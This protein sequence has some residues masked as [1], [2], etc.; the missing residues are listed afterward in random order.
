[1]ELCRCRIYGFPR[2]NMALKDVVT[3]YL[4]S[5]RCILFFIFIF[6]FSLGKLW[7]KNKGGFVLEEKADKLR[8]LQY[9]A[10]T[11]S[12]VYRF[13]FILTKDYSVFTLFVLFHVELIDF[14]LVTYD[15]QFP[16][17]LP[18][19][20]LPSVL[21]PSALVFVLSRPLT[22]CG[23]AWLCVLCFWPYVCAKRISQLPSFPTTHR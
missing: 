7:F 1:M 14:Y 3:N 11:L 19:V 4:V 18:F 20:L 23:S 9:Y 8:Y 6:C 2:G 10:R 15:A 21:P 17:V 5:C 16:S 22:K 13:Y 12:I